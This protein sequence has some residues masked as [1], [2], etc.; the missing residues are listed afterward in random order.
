MIAGLR[1]A[2]LGWHGIDRRIAAHAS[3]GG[4]LG[5]F[6]HELFWFGVKQAWACLVEALM[7]AQLIVT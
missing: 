1:A 6:A 7:L 5:V 4:R 2:R 3:R